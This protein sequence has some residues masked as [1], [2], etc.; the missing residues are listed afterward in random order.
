MPTKA[1]QSNT[2]ST[3]TVKYQQQHT[4]ADSRHVARAVPSAR[5]SHISIHTVKMECDRDESAFMAVA[6]T[7]RFSVPRAMSL[8]I[9]RESIASCLH[10]G[11]VTSEK[12]R[13]HSE[14]HS[15]VLFAYVIIHL[16]VFRKVDV[17]RMWMPDVAASA[18]LQ[19]IFKVQCRFLALSIT[20]LLVPRK[21]RDP[22]LVTR[23][24]ERALW[25][26][27]FS[28]LQCKSLD[29]DTPIRILSKIQTIGDVIAEQIAH[30]KTKS[31]EIS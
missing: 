31:T 13:S 19:L 21:A 29:V 23:T 20:H 24:G 8:I 27:G 30:L 4:S 18:V 2:Q 25:F 5:V 26:L 12:C 11:E 6:P 14:K 3:L 22:H 17:D 16:P 1:R 10:M 9:L 15:V 7:E 28:C